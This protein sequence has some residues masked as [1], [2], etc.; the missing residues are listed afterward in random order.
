MPVL[1]RWNAYLERVEAEK[2]VAKAILEAGDHPDSN[3]RV[4]RRSADGHNRDRRRGL[5]LITRGVG[6]TMPG[7]EPAPRPAS[8]GSEE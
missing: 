5:P 8:E 2:A 6:G 3:G 4:Y 7:T 1:P